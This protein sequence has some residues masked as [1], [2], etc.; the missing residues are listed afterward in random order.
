MR[1]SGIKSTSSVRKLLTGSF[2]HFQM[3]NQIKSVCFTVARFCGLALQ[4]VHNPNYPI[5]HILDMTNSPCHLINLQLSGNQASSIPFVLICVHIVY[6]IHLTSLIKFPNH[7]HFTEESWLISC[8][9]TRTWTNSPFNQ[10]LRFSLPPHRLQNCSLLSTLDITFVPNTFNKVQSSIQF[11]IVHLNP[12][13]SQ[14]LQFC[15]PQEEG[16]SWEK[17]GQQIVSVMYG[18]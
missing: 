3:Y 5:K 4:K 2:V 6:E 16:K 9:P 10:I 14:F 13:V 15:F 17:F 12:P 1:T 7:G 11:I 18:R 8:V